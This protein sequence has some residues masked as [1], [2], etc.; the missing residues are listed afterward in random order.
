MI[1]SD[2]RIQQLV[3]DRRLGIEPYTQEQLNPASYNVRLSSKALVW[4]R[5]RYDAIDLSKPIDPLMGLVE[6]GN[7]Q[8]KGFLL[9]RGY[10]ALFSTVERVRIPISLVARVEG[11]SS[12]GRLGLVIHQTAGFIDPGFEGH[13]TLEI[14][15]QNPQHDIVLRAGMQIAQL[16][17]E[18]LDGTPIQA[19]KGKYQTQIDQPVESR[20]YKEFQDA[21]PVR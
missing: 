12:L 17:F 8:E 19:Y 11:R 3:Y 20:I 14:M 6:F 2:H 16:V 10:A 13:V 4:V 1:L 5:S 7:T 18:M 15:N 21:E 9:Q